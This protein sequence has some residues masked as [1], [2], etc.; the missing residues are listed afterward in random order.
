[1]SEV[2]DQ[3]NTN[4]PVERSESAHICWRGSRGGRGD[5]GGREDAGGRGGVGTHSPCFA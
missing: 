4:C 5:A 1:M 3:N 2:D